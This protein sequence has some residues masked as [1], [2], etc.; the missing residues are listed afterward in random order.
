MCITCG[1]VYLCLETWPREEGTQCNMCGCAVYKG[2]PSTA[3]AKAKAKAK[4]EKERTPEG[5]ALAAKL[6]VVL[7]P[8]ELNVGTADAPST[9]SAF[10]AASAYAAAEAGAEAAAAEAADEDGFQPFWLSDMTDARIGTAFDTQP[11]PATN[12]LSIIKRADTVEALSAVRDAITEAR[13][14]LNAQWAGM[15]S[16]DEDDDGVDDGKDVDLPEAEADATFAGLAELY[17]DLY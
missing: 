14:A 7:R 13:Q 3:K 15:S 9:A 16:D 12:L 5:A 4:R 6:E 2:R 10:A 17:L 11:A 1:H 8:G